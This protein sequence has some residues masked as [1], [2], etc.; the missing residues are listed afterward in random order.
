[1]KLNPKTN[2][3]EPFLGGMPADCFAY[4]PDGESIAYVRAGDG[5]LWKCRKDGSGAVLL[6]DGLAAYRPRWSPDGRRIAFSGRPFSNTSQMQAATPF[7]AYTISANGGKREEVPGV[8]G[9]AF[10]PSW[11][12]D[13]KRIA[14]APCLGADTPSREQ[15]HVSIVNLETGAVEAV[16]GS[17]SI[18][19]TV[20]SPDGKWLAGMAQNGPASH[21]VVYSFATRRWTQLAEKETGAFH[22]SKDSRFL[23]GLTIGPVTEIVRIEIATRKMETVRAITDFNLTGVLDPSA[24][25]TPEDEPIVQ[26][27]V[28]SSQIYR[29]ERE[30]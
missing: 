17:D 11:S 7:R 25:W 21:P 23:S 6:D 26:K 28:S 22:W 5:Q 13:G 16:P 19:A 20:W 9:S 14:L 15:R 4:S 3:W 27:N 2:A 8:E 1:M 24:S 12:P 18:W 30:R 29:I 10:D